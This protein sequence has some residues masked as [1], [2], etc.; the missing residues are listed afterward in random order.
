MEILKRG[1]KGIF[2]TGSFLEV[3]SAFVIY[4][5]N[6]SLIECLNSLSKE[7]YLNNLKNI[8][9]LLGSLIYH[10]ENTVD[11]DSIK[12]DL[13]DKLDFRVLAIISRFFNDPELG[14][15]VFKNSDNLVAKVIVVNLI[16]NNEETMQF[17]REMT[18]KIKLGLSDEEEIESDEYLSKELFKLVNYIKEGY[19]YLF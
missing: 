15:Y 18:E 16:N 2:Y 8:N 4:N 3:M 19:S 10:L 5:D 14:E 9:E 17:R 13:I 7:N 1:S 11:Y 12:K 6:Y